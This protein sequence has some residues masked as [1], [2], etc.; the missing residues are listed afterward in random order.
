[1][2]R[3]VLVA[4]VAIMVGIAGCPGLD[5]GGKDGATPTGSPLTPME[6]SSPTPTATPTGDVLEPAT[7]AADHADALGGGSFTKYV[8]INGS[9]TPLIEERVLVDGQFIWAE[10]SASPEEPNTTFYRDLEGLSLRKVADTGSITY[11]HCP[12]PNA[13]SFVPTDQLDRGV[14]E[15]FVTATDWEQVGREQYRGT[16]VVRYEAEPGGSVSGFQRE[17]RAQAVN[18]RARAALLVGTDGIVRRMHVEYRGSGGFFI[19]TYQFS[20]VGAT[21]VTKPE[22]LDSAR[23]GADT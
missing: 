11:E 6:T 14:V 16:D 3:V 17:P 19:T 10:R 5:T 18:G 21:S 4:A 8:R 20:E 1:M 9:V 22:W 15:D 2:K 12:D 23:S 7:V 13:T